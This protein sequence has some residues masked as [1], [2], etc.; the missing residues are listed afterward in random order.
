MLAGQSRDEQNN[1]MGNT[2]DEEDDEEGSEDELQD[3]NQKVSCY[4]VAG[5]F[6]HN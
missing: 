5:A 3:K 4:F 6:D 2:S 1:R